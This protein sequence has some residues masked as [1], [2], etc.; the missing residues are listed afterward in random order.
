MEEE[1]ERYAIDSIDT[2]HGFPHLIR[3]DGVF[4]DVID[5]YKDKRKE[6]FMEYPL[7]IKFVGEKAVDT[8]G[9]CRD[10]FSAFLE[11]AYEK[12][13]MVLVH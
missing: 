2:H 9:V 3:R 8:G 4:E 7:R 10:M 11:K 1:R 5:L 6:I 12:V 13:L